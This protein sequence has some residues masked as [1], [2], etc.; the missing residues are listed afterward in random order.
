MPL[1]YA[2]EGLKPGMVVRLQNGMQA[3]RSALIMGQAL[4]RL[5]WAVFNE[6]SGCLDCFEATASRGKA[7]RGGT[8]QPIWASFTSIIASP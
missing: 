7:E 8:V 5:H 2:P 1:Q 6:C 4:A 3:R